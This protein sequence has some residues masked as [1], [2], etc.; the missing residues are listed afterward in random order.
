[1]EERIKTTNAC[2]ILEINEPSNQPEIIQINKSSTEKKLFVKITNL[3]EKHYNHQYVD[4]LNVLVE[5]FSE[6]GSCAS[7]GFYFTDIEHVHEFIHYG[8]NLRVVELPYSEIDF[9]CLPDGNGKWRANKIILGE[10]YSL[11]DFETYRF[12]AANGFDFYANAHKVFRHAIKNNFMKVVYHMLGMYSNVDDL[13]DVH[14]LRCAII[15]NNLVVVNLLIKVRYNK[16]GDI[17]GEAGI[18]DYLGI[19]L[20][21]ATCYGKIDV[22]HRLIHWIC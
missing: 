7:A 8:V 19:G 15:N 14:A 6:T 17:Y 20:E 4:G 12:L 2:D 10:K 21:I 9:K 22:M 5:P 11:A 1:M 18:E 13:C 16:I 3:E